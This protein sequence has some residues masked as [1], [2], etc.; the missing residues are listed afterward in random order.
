M[1]SKTKRSLE[2]SVDAPLTLS[3]LNTH[4]YYESLRHTVTIRPLEV[5]RSLE[6]PA[7]APD[8]ATISDHTRS[9]MISELTILEN[10][11]QKIVNLK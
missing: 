11:V 3:A 7:D 10:L 4:Y 5:K 9:T 2:E 6:E 8:P 1:S